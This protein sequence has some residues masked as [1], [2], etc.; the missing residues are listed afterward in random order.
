M[1]IGILCTE[2]YKKAEEI[3][4]F[5]TQ[6]YNAIEI[7]KYK[8][9]LNNI[10]VFIVL[11][12]DGFMLRS[13][14]KYYKYNIPFLGINCGN[15][16]FL[17]NKT[18][19]LK[20]NLINIINNSQTVTINPL[21]NEIITMDNKIF[22]NISINELTIIRNVYK[23]C[24]IDIKVNSKCMLKNYSGDGLVVSTPIGSTA[25]NSSLNGA[26]ISHKS[27]NIILS[28]ISPF[29]PRTFRSVILQNDNTLEFDINY[30]S[31]RKVSAFVDYIE[32]KNIKYAKTQ[33]NKNIKIKILFDKKLTM[34]E[35]ILI[36]QFNY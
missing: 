27:N 31:D 33:I 14:H 3:K 15:L 5:L 18:D 36:E 35:K 8:K 28:S 1:K 26:I 25:Y 4:I 2:I 32:Y 21:A 30:F 9:D 10:D 13:L 6:E 19:I 24:N 16:G 34:E 11:G 29:K 22:N 20:E 12:G 23:T 7:K 17:L